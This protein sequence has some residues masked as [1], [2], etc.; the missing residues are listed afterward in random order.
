MKVLV[1][2]ATGSQAKPV[3][4]ELIKKGHTAL[5]FSRDI[6]KA[7]DLAEAGAEL[8]EGDMANFEDTLVASKKADAVALLIP[9]FGAEPVTMGLNAIKA[10][11]AAQIKHIVWNTSGAIYSEKTGNPAYDARKEIQEALQTSDI[12]H[13]ILQPTL[14][15]ENLLGPWT[16]P[17]VKDQHKVAYPVP[18]DFK[19]GWL[20]SADMA[21]LVVAGLEKPTLMGNHFIVAGKAAPTGVELASVFT[22]ALEKNI[23]YYA[24]PPQE[25]GGILNSIMGEGAGDGVTAE[26]QAIWDG[27]NPV[28]HQDMAEILKKFDVEFMDLDEWVSTFKPLFVN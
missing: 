14:Y 8:I 28:M 27:A 9:T 11:K 1:Y 2:G 4:L 24:M 13:L 3:V 19:I 12:P 22:K 16:A 7:Q 23:D 21:K 20:P 10:A 15:A 5:A 25:F 26:Y 6:S 18:P 17:F